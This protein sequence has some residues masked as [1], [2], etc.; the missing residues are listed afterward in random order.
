MKGRGRIKANMT[1]QA[2]TLYGIIA[3]LIAFLII[4]SGLAV[5]YYYQYSQQV[6]QNNNYIDALKKANIRFFSNIVIDFGNG[7][8]VWYN[9][10]GVQP[11]SNLYIA[12]LLVTNG[13]VNA[14]WYA[15]YGEHLVT[16]ID[17]IQNTQAKSWYLW[18]YNNTASWQVAQ[19]GADQLFVNNASVFAWMFCGSSG[20]PN[21]SPTCTPP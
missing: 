18:T 5:L 9:D 6:V 20:S 7:S 3:L 17:G 15:Q 10:T 11:G 2:K 16:G 1:L 19:V 21:Y 14:T 8:H 12:T 13:N 4:V